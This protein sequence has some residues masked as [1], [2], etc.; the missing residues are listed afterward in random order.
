MNSK[1]N[2]EIMA[3]LARESA[4]VNARL[5]L[6]QRERH[7]GDVAPLAALFASPLERKEWILGQRIAEARRL[8]GWT[9]GELADRT[10]KI[11]PRGQGVKRGA[12]SLYEIGK[13]NPGPNEL[14]LLCEALQVS[15]N[16]LLY[17]L[18]DPFGESAY[19]W[20]Q[21]FGVTRHADI[22]AQM[23][24]RFSKLSMPQRLAI[25]TIIDSL[26]AA[27]GVR[28]DEEASVVARGELFK[29]ADELRQEVSPEP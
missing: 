8:R 6:V 19:A 20:Q 2:Q 1:I 17:S 10:A 11:D 14:I 3:D 23:V 24:Y 28:I 18:D 13:N 12:L 15:P 5:E 16:M 7:E 27:S 25:M 4:E 9:Q 26:L 22:Y 29:A 21:R